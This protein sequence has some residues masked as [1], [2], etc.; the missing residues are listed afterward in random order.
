MPLIE[1]VDDVGCDEVAGDDEKD[2]DADE[3]SRHHTSTEMEDNDGQDRDCTEPVY[4][5]SVAAL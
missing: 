5:G 4:I 3:T 1:L 2:V